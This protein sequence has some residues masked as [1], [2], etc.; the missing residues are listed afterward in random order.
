[1]N[2]RTRSGWWK[3]LIIFYR[4]I[5]KKCQVII[6]MLLIQLD[7]TSQLVAIRLTN[8][9]VIVSINDANHLMR[10]QP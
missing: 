4:V 1:M 9:P 2:I 3:E 10:A 7:V 5:V 6:T 8:G